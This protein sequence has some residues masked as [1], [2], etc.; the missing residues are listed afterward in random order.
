MSSIH[1]SALAQHEHATLRNAP[2]GNDPLAA[3]PPAT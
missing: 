3:Q 2:D 1:A